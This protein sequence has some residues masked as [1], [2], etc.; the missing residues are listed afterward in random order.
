M[1]LS[2]V[3]GSV[4]VSVIDT[5]TGIRPEDLPHIFDRFYRADRSR[6]RSREGAGLGL[7]IAREIVE[8][9]GSA[10]QVESRVNGG[11]RFSFALAADKR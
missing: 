5:G 1:A 7:A 2:R 4:E 9:H 8:M 6:D 10:L 11:T 3:S